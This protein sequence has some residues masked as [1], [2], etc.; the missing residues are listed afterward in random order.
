MK[1][2][3]VVAVDDEALA[4][5]RVE[6]LLRR[7]D[8]VELVGLARTA[9]EAIDRLQALKPDVVLLDIRLTDGDGFMVVKALTAPDAPQVVFTTA[10]DEYAVR[11]FDV[12]ATDFLVKPLEPARLEQALAKARALRDTRDAAGRLA[13]A[14]AEARAWTGA[15]EAEV[16]ADRNGTRVRVRAGE[17]AWVEAERD[18]ARLHASSGRHLVRRTIAALAEEL[19]A[20]FLRVSRS[21]LVRRS[22]VQAFRRCDRGDYRVVLPDGVEL[23]VGPTY[24][25]AVREAIF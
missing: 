14:E 15:E 9:D 2:L 23:R 20:D 10:F 3:T 7:I 12:S 18:Y 13:A 25:K 17:I 22:L 19:G 24:L 8:G 5:R 6:L 11:A 4:L 1:S 21:A 16:W